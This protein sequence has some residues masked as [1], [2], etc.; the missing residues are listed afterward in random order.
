MKCVIILWLSGELYFFSC[1]QRQDTIL[2]TV[3]CALHLRTLSNANEH[4]Y[5][6]IMHIL[7]TS[8]TSVVLLDLCAQIYPEIGL[9][10]LCYELALL[11]RVQACGVDHWISFQEYKVNLFKTEWSRKSQSLTKTLIVSV[12]LSCPPTPFLPVK[13]IEWQQ[14]K[15]ARFKQ[16]PLEAWPWWVRT[17]KPRNRRFDFYTHKAE[18]SYCNNCSTFHLQLN[19]KTL[20]HSHTAVML[21]T[22]SLLV[23]SLHHTH[24]IALVQ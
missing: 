19:Q 9:L 16:T 11:L 7:F 12:F 1:Q 14:T 3:Y 20:Q 4:L 21:S 23:I 18:T 17:P 5:W 2:S 24:L 13:Q 22:I 10:S 15:C 8:G 6:G